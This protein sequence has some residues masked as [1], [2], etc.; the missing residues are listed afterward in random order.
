VAPKGTRYPTEK[1]LATKYLNAACDG[2][3]RLG[4]VVIERS[5][6]VRPEIIYEMVGG[7]LKATQTVRRNDTTLRELNPND[8]EFIHA[9]PPCTIGVRRFVAGFGVDVNKRLTLSLKDLEPGNRS[10]IQLSSGE[11]LPLPVK[12]L[13]FVKL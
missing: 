8:R 10:Y 11:R 1:P 7:Q 2:T 3:T 5:G 6:M 4:M 12:D 9:D 13:P